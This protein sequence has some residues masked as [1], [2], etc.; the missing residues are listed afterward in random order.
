MDNTHRRFQ[1]VITAGLVL[2]VIFQHFG[3]TSLFATCCAMSVNMIWIWED[4]LAA[5]LFGK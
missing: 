1:M 4:W 3:Q 2:A 5:K